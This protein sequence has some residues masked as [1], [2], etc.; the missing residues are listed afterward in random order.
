[1]Q[2]STPAIAAYAPRILR[3]WLQR[4]P[5]DTFRE[6]DGS[7]AFVDIS[8]F[9]RLSESL[10]RR[11]P[12]GA[13][14]LT[15]TINGCFTR[16]LEVAYDNGGSLLKFGGDA[17]LLLFTGEAHPAAASR[18]AVGMSRSLDEIGDLDTPDG[19]VA[20]RMSTGVHSGIFHF[21]LVGGSHRELIVAGPAASATVRTEAAAEVGEVLVS[22]ALADQLPDDVLGEVRD[23]ARLLVEVPPGAPRAIPFQPA[24]RPEVLEAGIPLALREQ[25]R[26][27]GAQPEHRRVTVAFLRFQGLDELIRVD[28]A[29]RAAVELDAF[30]RDVQAAI[31][32]RDVTFLG[33]DIDRDGG[34][35]ILAAGAPASSGND[36]ERMLLSL[37]EI[38]TV[39]RAI[40]VHVGVN[41]DHVFAGDIGP[42]YRRSYTV[43]GDGVNL[44][45]RLMGKSAAGQILATETVL[46]NSRTTFDTVALAPFR[47]KG[48][49]EPVRA[50]SVGDATGSRVG[51]RLTDPPLIGRERE[52]GLLT[53]MVRDARTGVG[54]LVEIVGEPGIGKTRLME[55][56]RVAGEGVGFHCVSCELYER[57]IPYAPFRRLL[58]SAVGIPEGVDNE[59]A[60]ARLEAVVQGEA[61]DLVAWLPLLGIPLDVEFPPTGETASLDAQFRRTRLHES[62]FDLLGALWPDPTVLV[63]EDAQWMDEASADLLGYLV[64]RVH[65]APWVVAVTRR[66]ADEGPADGEPPVLR[67]ELGPLD[68]EATAELA[69]VATQDDPLPPHVLDV[70]VER[71]GGNPLFLQ[72]LIAAMLEGGLGGLPDSVEAVVTARVD[73]LPPE[74][75]MVLRHLSVLGQT[76]SLD[77][78]AAVLPEGTDVADDLVWQQLASF[79][80]RER[81]AIRFRSTLIRDAAYQG[82]PFRDRRRLHAAAGDTLAGSV[83]GDEDDHAELLSYHYLLAGRFEEAWRHSLTAAERAA[84]IYANVEASRF[85]RRA[86]ESADALDDVDASELSDTW[87]QLG[88]TLERLGEFA[89][90]EEAYRE[91]LDLLDPDPVDEARLLL[92]QAQA[93]VWLD[94]YER[95]L[96]LIG[97]GLALVEDL[98]QQDASRQRAQLRAWY[99]TFSQAQGRHEIAVEWANRAIEDARRAR[100]RDALAH[101]FKT[102]DL[103]YMELRQ[104]ENAVYSEE[105][106]ALYQE[107]DDVPNQAVVLNN[108]GAVAYL[109][110]RWDEAR[111]LYERAVALYERVGNRVGA[112]FSRYNIAEILTDQGHLE[113]AERLFMEVERV[114]R[115]SSFLNGIAYVQLGRGRIAAAVEHFDEALELFT[116]ARSGW[117]EIGADA[118]VVEADARI[119]ECHLLRGE[120]DAA[121]AVTDE[122][123]GGS[124]VGDGAAPQAALIHRVRGYAFIQRGELD[125]AREELERSR[126]EAGAHESAY[127]A[128]LTDRALAELVRRE[129][130]APD[131][132]EETSAAVLAR[133]GVVATPSVPLPEPKARAHRSS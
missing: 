109:Q 31:D 77:V 26:A 52:L 97:R 12:V 69:H 102:L 118:R 13:E 63:V 71:S 5:D 122:A 100:D 37:R 87:E 28:G 113:E 95:A 25:A 44:A 103:V 89:R 88:V 8:G 72:E 53:D 117:E 30:V 46:G 57:S 114:W 49:A 43:M 68:A 92:K 27:G 85:Y 17:L 126:R 130:G 120:P 42:H 76:A 110:S 40:A 66:E 9:T 10:S 65:E 6:V 78:A 104:P 132:L 60:A 56:F 59:G 90:A 105:A 19:P 112:C 16:L 61:P 1:M 73:Q 111:E 14:E 35:V 54:Q 2:A 24:E 45:A 4:T 82:L 96:D 108:M 129:G 101:S 39:D 51:G 81:G 123:L 41:T 62:M 22:G 48:K 107:L 33:T 131:E 38:V 133:L 18:A 91:S 94:D 32:H 106:L 47:V 50:L 70:L 128:A 34:K 127:E 21:F 121:I 67:L 23:G 116:R 119:A 29:E 20:L 84:R 3:D 80:S 11:G 64:S 7:L 124:A 99:A 36:E 15:D 125:R 86:L 93:R 83:G 115:A 58:R 75:R 79:L 74:S 98:E 55:A